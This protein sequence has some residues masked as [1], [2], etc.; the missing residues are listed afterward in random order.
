VEE[1]DQLEEKLRSAIEEVRS[2]RDSLR[3]KTSGR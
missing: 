2:R 1:L 3:A